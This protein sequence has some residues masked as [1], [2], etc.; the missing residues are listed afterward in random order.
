MPIAPPIRMLSDYGPEGVA[1]PPSL[2]DARRYC[3]QL[4]LGHYENF[5]VLSGLVPQSIRDDFAAV[6]AF[7]RWSDD[8]GDETG[9]D[10]AARA[11]SESLLRWWRGELAA[12]VA[13]ARSAAPERPLRH[14]VFVALAE[15]LRRHPLSAEPFEHLIDAFV[16]DQ[17]VTRYDTWDQLLDYCARSANPVGRI[18]LGL[19]G[20]ADPELVA[21][22]DATCT[23]L[24]LTNFWQDVRR[25]LIE[26]DRVYLPRAITGWSAEQLRDWMARP[27][28]PAARVP[29]IRGVRPLVAE[30]RKL[31]EKGRPLPAALGRELGP[32]V[33]LFGAG[34]EAVLRS[35]E[36]IGCATLWERPKLGKLGKM[37]LLARAWIKRLRGAA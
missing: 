7:C 15:T 28:D 6:Y 31:F 9:A 4:T 26:R 12:C 37:S 32:V 2:E 25:D 21:M 18:V 14:P 11:R 36:R 23:A 5:T 34:G 8:L 30:T 35:V 20:R 19:G 29:F 10:E 16:Q 33:W 24:Q 17:R 27:D 13:A 22:S 1:P 3:R